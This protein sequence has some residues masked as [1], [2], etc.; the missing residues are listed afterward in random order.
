MNVKKIIM[1]SVV[2]LKLDRRKLSILGL[3][4]SALLLAS[5]ANYRGPAYQMAQDDNKNFDKP[6]REPK[7][8]STLQDETLIEGRQDYVGRP[9]EVK[10]PQLTVSEKAEFA[11]EVI[12]PQLGEKL[13]PEQAFNN[14]PIPAF[15]NEVY[16]NQLG[17]NFVIQPAIRSTEDLVTLRLSTPMKPG[18]FYALVTRTL[19]Q[20]G[21]ATSIDENAL[22]FD[23]SDAA[24]KDSVPLILSGRTLPEVPMDNRTVFQ[25]YELTALRTPEVKGLLDSMLP[26]KDITITEDITRNALILQGK[27]KRVREAIAAIEL[28]DKPTMSGMYSTI[29]QPELNSAKELADNLISIMKTEGFY[30]RDSN[31]SATVK[32]LPIE[33]TGQVVAFAKSE[34]VIDYIIEWAQILE[35][36]RESDIQNG[37]FSYQVQSTK[38]S[39][40]VGLLSSLGVASGYSAPSTDESDESAGRSSNSSSRSA[41]SEG[42]S[43]GGRFAVDDMLNT[44]LYS[45]SGKDW[46]RALSM[47]KKLDKPAPSVMIEVVLAEVSLEESEDSAIEWLFNSTVGAYDAVGST[48]GAFG[49]STSGFSYTLRKGSTRLA[50]NFLYENRRTTIR[51]RPR[52][53]VKS[54]ESASIDIGDRVPTITSNIQSTISDNAQIVQS[55]S[56]QET[57]VLLDIKPTIHASGFVDLEVS[58][59]LSEAVSTSTSSINSPTIRTRSIDTV[60]TLRDGGAVLIGGLIRS[61]DGEGELGIPVLGQLPLVGPLFRGDNMEQRRT[62]LLI[63][64]IPYI[65]NSPDEAESLSDELQ[66]VRFQKL[67]N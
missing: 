2:N 56:Y 64:I 60:L 5:C 20:Y 33:N 65:L 34:E 51:S 37:L 40:I 19:A 53:M 61:N 9:L 6:L 59:E 36:Q 42:N 43:S 18:D 12:V 50:M 11:R 24:A 32:V 62:E 25:I 44:I 66:K 54:G 16:G 47:I 31:G 41:N 23:Y 46:S 15:I 63:M 49:Q 38:A 30:V 17:L 21:V 8:L 35:S 29:L 10:T 39:H 26:R 22:V 55:V 67:D 7:K 57:G 48:I 4:L 28:L 27:P 45:G 3:S 14:L 52:L 13:I 58:Q 1:K